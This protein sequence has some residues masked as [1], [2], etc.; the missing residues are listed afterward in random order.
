MS[1]A[2][3]HIMKDGEEL[4]LLR[5]FDILAPEE[6]VPFHPINALGEQKLIDDRARSR[7]LINHRGVIK[8]STSVPP[9]ES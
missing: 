6:D 3:A 8:E 1:A 4:H 7:H 9:R 2:K 5:A